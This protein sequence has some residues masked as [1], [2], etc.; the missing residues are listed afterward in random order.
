M[1]ALIVLMGLFMTNL[2][3]AVPTVT[4]SPN[5]GTGGTCT[6]SDDSTD[7]LGTVSIHIAQGAGSNGTQCTL[8][9]ADTYQSAPK[10]ILTPASD[11]AVSI[12]ADLSNPLPMPSGEYVT[13]T[14]TT[15]VLSKS[16][17]SLQNSVASNE[18]Y[19]YSCTEP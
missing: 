9:F 2:A 13:S 12:I 17:V 1:K 15:L 16:S 10:C 18:V 4:V 8:T 14:T 11:D 6:V 5:L 3:C 19:N 7:I